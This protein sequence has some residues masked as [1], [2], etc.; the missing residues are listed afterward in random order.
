MDMLDIQLLD[1]I[2]AIEDTLANGKMV[3]GKIL[4]DKEEITQ[5]VEEMRMSLPDDIK[6][7]KW[8]SEERSR[9]VQEARNEAAM[10]IS[11]AEEKAAR[12]VESNEITQQAIHK[13]EE[14][15]ENAK[16]QSKSMRLGAKEYA[17]SVLEQ[18]KND[19]DSI[20]V[21]IDKNRAEIE[22]MM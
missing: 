4:V 10:I 2:E 17:S 21:E 9:L 20:S 11:E 18:L 22:N 16:N 8:V 15:L 6:K 5:L 3:F 13:A 7:A 1:L 12:L 19:V 14:I